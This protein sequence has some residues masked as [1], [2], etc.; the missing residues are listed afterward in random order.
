MNRKNKIRQESWLDYGGQGTA[1]Q[2]GNIPDFDT[3]ADQDFEKMRTRVLLV[4][5]ISTLEPGS[6]SYTHLSLIHI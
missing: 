1:P 4:P 5:N 6:S 3:K 2:V